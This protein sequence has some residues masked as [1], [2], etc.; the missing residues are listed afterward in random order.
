MAVRLPA[1]LSQRIVL[2]ERTIHRLSAYNNPLSLEAVFRLLLRSEAV[3]SSRI[4]GY[5]PNS[6]K[7]AMAVLAGSS[8]QHIAGFSAAAAAV[9]RNVSI[10]SDLNPQLADKDV[11]ELEDFI[12]MQSSLVAETQ[13]K[14]IRHT[15]NWIGGSNYHPLTAAFVPPPPEEVEGLLEDLLTYLNGADHSALVQAALVH[16]QFETIHPFPDGNGRVGRAMIHT[17]LQR[18][19]LTQAAVLPI[20]MVLGTLSDRYVDGL[21]AFRNGE[22]L[23]WIAFFV[24]AAEIAAEKAAQIAQDVAALEADWT[25]RVNDYRKQQGL[26]RALRSD[27]TESRVLD[28]LPST[29]LVTVASVQSLLGTSSTAAARAALESLTES[30]VLRKR[31]IGPGGL[32]GYFADDVFRLVDDAERQLASTQFDT[33]LSPP[34]RQNVPKHRE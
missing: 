20:S 3:A 19:G 25:D 31:S 5:A 9:A 16:A 34:S 18:R 30:G 32:Q 13:L 1:E 22:V 6:D 12:T 23:D 10:L 2:V 7:V 21:T 29:P 27:S 17:V 4:E 28:S 8:S 11:L 33:R 15:Q 26:S 24:D 14:G